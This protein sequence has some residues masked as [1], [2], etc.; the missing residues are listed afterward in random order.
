[1]NARKC[2]LIL[3]LFLF[4]AGC[5]GAS[6][7]A[8]S[9]NLEVQGRIQLAT[10]LRNEV[11]VQFLD[12]DGGLQ[13]YTTARPPQGEFHIPA[14]PNGSGVRPGVYKVVVLDFSQKAGIPEAW[15]DPARTPLKV[16]VNEQTAKNLI[17]GE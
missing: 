17:I 12:A 8:G 14:P 2:V 3:V 4:L 5:Q 1:M 16:T 9:T 6:G 11:V 7:P 10:G 15:Q 13:A